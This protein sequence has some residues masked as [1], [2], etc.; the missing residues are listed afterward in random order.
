MSDEVNAHLINNARRQVEKARINAA[1]SNAMHRGQ[2]PDR[3]IADS[4]DDTAFSEKYRILG[5]IHRGG[6]GVVYRAVQRSAQREVAIKV[7][8]ES[9]MSS[10]NDR[11]R[12]DREIQI[13][14]G[15]KH[16][17]IVAI[18]D[19]GISNGHFY[20][21]M[22]YIAG[23]T[24]HE[25]VVANRPAINDTLRIFARI[26]DA[27]N[28]A[29]LRGIIHRDI[30]PS[31]IRIDEHG[32]PFVLDFGLARRSG[33]S[34]DPSSAVDL[35]TQ[36]GQ[37]VGSAPWASPEQAEGRHEDL[38]IRSDVYSLG[39]QLYHVLTGRFPYSVDGGMREVLN[40]IVNAEP[41]RPG[42]HRND[43]DNEVETIVLK[44]LEKSPDRRYQGAGALC[45]DIERYLAGEP[46]DAKRDSTTYLIRKHI[47]RNKGKAIT[48]MLFLAVAAAGFIASVTLWRR[49]ENQ[50]QAAVRAQASEQIEKRKAELARDKAL[51]EAAKTTAINDFIE[52]M[53]TSIQPGNALAGAPVT[54]R[55]V[56]DDASEAID[57]GYLDKTPDVE[58]T[59]RIILG[60]TYRLLGFEPEAHKHMLIACEQLKALPT[61]SDEAYADALFELG[62]LAEQMGDSRRAE[63]L[64]RESTEIFRRVFG[65]RHES[66]ASTM[67]R[68]AI[69]LLHQA[70]FDESERVLNESLRLLRSH[71]H[72]CANLASALDSKGKLLAQTGRF[73]QANA[74]FR[75]ALALRRKLH[76]DIHLQV[77]ET[78]H[79]LAY[80]QQVWGRPE[81][82]GTLFKES[83]DIRRQVMEPDHPALGHALYYYAIF[84]QEQGDMEGAEATLREALSIQRP[85]FPK[86]NRDTFL[87]LRDLAQLLLLK[88]GVENAIEAESLFRECLRIPE[89]TPYV[90]RTQR[91][92]VK[93]MLGS[94][95]YYQRRFEEAEPL[96]LEAVG[97][98]L[99]DPTMDMRHK[100]NSIRIV[101][102][103]YVAWGRFDDAEQWN[104]KLGNLND[105][106]F[107]GASG[108]ASD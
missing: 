15:L 18:H 43:I 79:N 76:G 36:T 63:S 54:V 30:K 93:R 12:F 95:L 10:A 84:L 20:Y 53:F 35:I 99:K 48:A 91:L 96:L 3:F 46:I 51:H 47:H 69:V 9:P 86:G 85:R 11:V 67:S 45:R 29:H 65:D 90:S 104:N 22:D 59:I 6:Q 73:D 60:K 1:S 24:L 4:A 66:V 32:T 42:A 100:T 7:L 74:S 103:L 52:G 92:F 107:S 19:S 50:K 82:A 25:Y 55:Q 16:P 89:D 101:E 77:A 88:Q 78:L 105:V 39:V 64:M 72:E 37:F 70:K 61:R 28:A 8:R 34:E 26:C 38:D 102:S 106:Q 71:G 31:N 41:S 40:S 21:V 13:L 87:N 80:V 97:E 49:A 108:D 44:C 23:H 17:N 5:E 83:I 98:I 33:E 58:S 75:E 14:G 56:L 2:H 27:I 81:E 62:T 94:A 68:L 57:D